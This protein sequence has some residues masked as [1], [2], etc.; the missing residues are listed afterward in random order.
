[1]WFFFKKRSYIDNSCI[2]SIFSSLLNFIVNL[3]SIFIC[4]FLY[5]YYF[6]MGSEY[7]SV[8]NAAI[9]TLLIAS[10]Y[11]ELKAAYLRHHM[12]GLN[13]AEVNGIRTA[14]YRRWAMDRVGWWLG[15]A[16]AAVATRILLSLRSVCSVCSAQLQCS[17]R[18]QC[19]AIVECDARV[20]WGSSFSS[21]V[22]RSVLIAAVSTL[23]C[24]QDP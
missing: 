20:F 6:V 22:T 1:M 12:S 13:A 7:T 21:S 24:F 5:K 4:L 11:T 18:F 17:W 23:V 19:C 16:N 9:E 3:N 15:V 8:D 14:S 2:C 10:I